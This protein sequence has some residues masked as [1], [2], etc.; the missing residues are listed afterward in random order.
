VTQPDE[1][2]QPQWL[3]DCINHYRRQGRVPSF[4]DMLLWR[5]ADASCRMERDL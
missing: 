2:K 3:T 1:W 5:E 4:A